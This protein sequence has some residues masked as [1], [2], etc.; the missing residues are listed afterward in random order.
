MDRPSSPTEH[1]GADAPE[2]TKSP[3]RDL[4]RSAALAPDAAA[5]SIIDATRPGAAALLGLAAVLI[6]GV[7]V[8]GAPDLDAPWV[9]GDEFYFIVDNPDVN[10]LAAQSRNLPA[11]ALPE[12][13]AHIWTH[14]HEDLY[15]PVPI[16]TYALEW[17][18]TN[19]APA[20]FRRT[21]LAL[22]ALNALLLWLVLTDLFRRMPG[23]ERRQAVIAGWLL[24]LLWALHPAMSA[25]YAVDM[26]RTHLLAAFFALLALWFEIQGLAGRGAAWY[27]AALVALLLA[28][29]SKV[30]VGWVL[31]VLVLE[32]TQLGWRRALGSWRVYATAAI[33]AT[34]AYITIYT[35][36]VYGF[37]EDAAKGLFGDPV[38]RSALAAWIYFRDLLTPIWLSFWHL[39]DP[40]TGWGY[41][42]VWLGLLLALATVVH[43]VHAARR[44]E[45][46][47][48]AVGWAWFWATLLP[49]IGLVGARQ[50]AA[51]DRYLYQPAMGL[52][53]VVGIM[54][55]GALAR[56]SDAVAT[57][58]GRRATVAGLVLAAAYLV[59][60]LPQVALRRSVVMGAERLAEVNAGDPRAP[61]GPGGHVRLCSKPSVVTDGSSNPP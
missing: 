11:S 45:T 5:G 34:F 28:M 51:A 10:P 40:R 43:A 37:M 24:A 42:R 33:C 21:D 49:V 61:R 31:L 27:A 19:G 16:V 48:I 41:W 6:L 56:R 26:G 9:S 7:F 4:G 25:T 1:T 15:Q 55:L 29:L 30:L 59:L 14:V 32:A 2:T 36:M 22:H 17:S 23:V 47:L 44:R 60:D 39:A 46:A 58:W 50:A 20:S 54:L 57:A 12:R 8:A 35:S 38:S 3:N 18:L 13:L 52:A 53:L